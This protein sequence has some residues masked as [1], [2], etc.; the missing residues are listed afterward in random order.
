MS[1]TGSNFQQLFAQDPRARRVKTSSTLFPCLR[2]SSGIA[3]ESLISMGLLAYLG[4]PF[5]LEFELNTVK[6]V[7]LTCADC[8]WALH[9]VGVG[10]LKAIPAVD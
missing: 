5:Q 7:S 1:Q 10:F 8:L 9:G 3:I 2:F 4:M 6:G